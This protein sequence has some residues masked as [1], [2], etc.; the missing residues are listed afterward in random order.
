MQVARSSGLPLLFLMLGFSVSSS[1]SAAPEDTDAHGETKHNQPPVSV[2]GSDVSLLPTQYPQGNWLALQGPVRGNEP[3]VLVRIAGHEIDA[4]LDTGAMTSLMS[5]P[6]AKRLG[7]EE[8]TRKSKSVMLMDSH[9]DTAKGHRL[10]IPLVSMQKHEWVDAEFLVF[11]E[12]PEL[13]LIGADLLQDVDI[14]LAAEEGWIGLFEAGQAPA[15]PNQVVIPVERERRQLNVQAAAKNTRKHLIPFS[16]VVDT[17]ATHTS[18][19]ALTGINHGLAADLSYAVQTRA[20]GGE[21]ESR[22]RFVLDPLFVG[23]SHHDVGLVLALASTIQ[24]GEGEALLGNDVLMRNYTLISFQKEELRFAPSPPRPAYRILGPA[25][26]RCEKSKRPERACLQVRLDTPATLDARPDAL[27]G[28]CL[29]VDAD[30]V[31]A[32]RSMELTITARDER[33]RDLFAGGVLQ[34]LVTVGP[35]GLQKC[36]PLWPHLAHL[37]LNAKSRL[38]LRW[39]RGEGF[40]WSCDAEQTECLAF[41]GPVA[42]LPKK[43]SISTEVTGVLE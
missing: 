26:A 22:G 18:V 4:V 19:P 33:G 25:G 24:N 13:L 42:T 9:G 1:S 43:P 23:K 16:L 10:A 20:V 3:R 2:W 28:I 40:R 34:A 32:G 31:Y 15:L 37:G 14:L 11:G 41:T 29:A 7:L 21:Q 35:H 5:R 39:V 12:Q 36:F 27:P 6:L 30:P 8:R 17:G 38:S